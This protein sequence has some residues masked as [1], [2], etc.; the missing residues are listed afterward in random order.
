MFLFSLLF[1]S[2]IPTTKGLQSI[3]DVLKNAATIQITS[4]GMQFVSIVRLLLA[5]CYQ[6][7]EFSSKLLK[8]GV[9]KKSFHNLERHKQQFDLCNGYLICHDLTARVTTPAI[10]MSEIPSGRTM[11]FDH[12]ARDDCKPEVK[13]DE[14]ARRV[15]EFHCAAAAGGNSVTNYRTLSPCADVVLG[16]AVAETLLETLALNLVPD[17]AKPTAS[18]TL[19]SSH[20]PASP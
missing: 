1:D 11:V 15:I 19:P 20:A 16:I 4:S 6:G 14:L 8:G 3:Q 13:E 10:L 18:W 5:A 17:T 12:H 2:W 7:E 9:N